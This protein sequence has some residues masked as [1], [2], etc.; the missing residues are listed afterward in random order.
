MIRHKIA[1]E[2]FGRHIDQFKDKGLM[3]SIIKG[4]FVSPHTGTPFTKV[5]RLLNY[6]FA[7]DAVYWNG[8]PVIID[9][10]RFIYEDTIFTDVA[11]EFLG[12]TK[13]IIKFPEVKL[14]GVGSLDYVLV[15]HRLIEL[16]IVDF[17]IMELQA[18]S[19]TG[20]GKLVEN[21]KDLVEKGYSGMKSTYNFGMNTYNTIKLSYIQML[22]KGHVAEKWS[23]HN[24]WIMQ[25]FISKHD[26]KI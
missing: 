1:A 22:M 9:P 11:N 5:S 3:P 17:V 21:L 15:K 25:D 6:P 20:T 14:K 24:V 4:G 7:I 18:D 2:I 8:I 23:K 16:D 19:T 10:N 12:G 26:R 13:N